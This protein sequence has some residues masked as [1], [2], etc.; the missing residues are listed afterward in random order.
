M[1][2]S[3]GAFVGCTSTSSQG[4]SRP[5]G[6]QP[7]H[8]CSVLWATDCAVSCSF[9][10]PPS[11]FSLHMFFFLYVYTFNKSFLSNYRIKYS[12]IH[13][14]FNTWV[15]KYTYYHI[16][17]ALESQSSWGHVSVNTFLI[18]EM[19]SCT[20]QVLQ[21]FRLLFGCPILLCFFK[22]SLYFGYF[23]LFSLFNKNWIQNLALARQALM[24]L[25][26]ISSSIL[27]FFDEFFLLVWLLQAKKNCLC[28]G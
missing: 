25:S 19:I 21:A 22:D 12:G 13:S 4:L 8:R 14:Y 15:N 26:Y 9:W 10:Y 7:Q 1:K 2:L 3:R 23:T 5:A 28:W 18:A 24:S 11:G 6:P 17:S 27:L 16:C 20:M